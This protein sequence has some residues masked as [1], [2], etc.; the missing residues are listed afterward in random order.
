MEFHEELV[1]GVKRKLDEVIQQKKA[2]KKLD[3]QKTEFEN[4]LLQKSKELAQQLKDKTKDEE[5]LK[6]QFDSVWSDWVRELTAGIKPIEDIDLEEDQTKILHELGFEWALIDERRNSGRYKKISEVGDYS[7]YVT[8]TKYQEQSDKT[9]QPQ[10][11][12]L[13]EK[14]KEAFDQAVITVD[15][16]LKGSL[17]HE[18]QQQIRLLI[19]DVDKQSLDT[20]KSKPV[21]TRGYSLAYLQEVAKNVKE[22]VTEFESERKYALKK[23]FTVDLLLYVLDRAGRWLSESHNEFKKK[24]DAHVYLENR[25]DQYYNVF[26][27]FCKGSSSA[28]VLGELICDKLKVSIIEAVCN[29][30][31]IDLAGEMKCNFP[32][33][34]GNRLN[35]EKHVLKSLAEKEDFSGF[36]TY[37]QRPKEHVKSFIKEEVKK[38]IFTSHK[39]KA[40]DI[41]K[42]NVEDMKKFVSQALFTAT[43]KVKTQRG[44]T[45]MWLQEFCTLIKDEL[46]VDVIC[47]ENFQD[48]KSFDF[49][50]EEIEKGFGHIMEEMSSLSLEK[51]NEFRL[52]PDQILIDQL[53]KCCWVNWIMGELELPGIET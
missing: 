4:K 34:N 18:D 5:K 38:Y 31:A 51:M 6:Q 19:D 2:C 3:D 33:F 49:L 7:G 48:K 29:N 14:V 22:K 10:K 20:I 36:I 25:R 53:C 40:R 35:L 27:S 46:T 42:K 13:I 9:Q 15:S 47:L 1:R 21:A 37:I 50:K 43:D 17:K 11:R 52:K 23:E 39:D 12:G 30:T 24:N 41:L 44:D 28:V 26:R 8:V 16:Y 32:A 45:D